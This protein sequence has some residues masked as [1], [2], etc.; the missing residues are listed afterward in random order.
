[1]KGKIWILSTLFFLM[2]LI[3]LG[4]KNES[5]GSQTRCF[6]GWNYSYNRVS[7]T[8]DHS[9]NKLAYHCLDMTLEID[10]NRYL[11]VEL[12][13]GIAKQHLEDP[14]DF[15]N[16]PISM[17]VNKRKFDSSFWGIRLKSEFLRK[18]KFSLLA[19]GEFQYFNVSTA[20]IPISLPIVKGTAMFENP[21]YQASVDLAAQFNILPGLTVFAGPQLNLIK[22]KFKLSESLQTLMG[23]E[24]LSYKQAHPI[25]L[26]T[27]LNWKGGHFKFDLKLDGLSKI[28]LTTGVSYIF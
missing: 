16:L 23:K 28:M 13:A 6:V 2:G 22:G 27:G 17:Q 11:T 25:G 7:V 8:T 26:T 24:T 14:V 12:I 10:F 1:M 15:V 21:F 4:A 3:S 18:Y 20:E 5:A 9:T 19:C